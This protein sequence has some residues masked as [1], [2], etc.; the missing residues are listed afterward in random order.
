MTNGKYCTTLVLIK[1]FEEMKRVSFDSNVKILKNEWK[2]ITADR[3]RF[4]LRK[5]KIEE[6]LWKIVF[7]LLGNNV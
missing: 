7:F 5:Q 6:W 2:R 4:E 3:H 1:K